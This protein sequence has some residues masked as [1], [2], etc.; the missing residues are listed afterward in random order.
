MTV[1]D[2]SGVVDYLIGDEAFEEVAGL[3]TA[4]RSVAVPDLLVFEVVAVFRRQVLRESLAAD[5]ARSAIE[6]LGAFPI[7]VF[8]SLPLRARV[9]ELRENFTAA[10]GFFVALAERLDEPFATK[11]RALAAAARSHTEIQVIDLGPESGT[12]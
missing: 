12:T 5:R 1:L 3:L 11:D 6:D 8:G 2:T 7:E 9:W 4:E 10:D